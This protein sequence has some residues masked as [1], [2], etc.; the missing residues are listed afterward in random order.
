MKTF[1]EN[2]VIGTVPFT[3][4]YV[5]QIRRAV[6]IRSK[7]ATVPSER[8]RGPSVPCRPDR[9]LWSFP[10]VKRTS[11]IIY[12]KTE[13]GHRSYENTLSLSY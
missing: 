8:L 2:A 11:D 12:N 6:D 10:D 9:P 3:H 4:S 13:E 5:L 1:S 7:L